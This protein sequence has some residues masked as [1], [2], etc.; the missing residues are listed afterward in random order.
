MMTAAV[1]GSGPRTEGDPKGVTSA[2]TQLEVDRLTDVADA[3]HDG[4]RATLY[5]SH[6]Q[7]LLCA[8]RLNDAIDRAERWYSQR[9]DHLLCFD[10]RSAA[11]VRRLVA[12]ARVRPSLAWSSPLTS[13]QL[14]GTGSVATCRRAACSS[15]ERTARVVAPRSWA[16]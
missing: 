10:Q 6:L 7:A 12:E 9:A 11:T 16:A 8:A 13:V 15:A 1:H 5:R 4:A 3:D 2:A 14:G